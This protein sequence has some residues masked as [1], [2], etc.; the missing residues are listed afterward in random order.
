MDNLAPPPSD[1]HSIGNHELRFTVQT[2]MPDGIPTSFIHVVVPGDDW[3]LGDLEALVHEMHREFEWTAGAY[4]DINRKSG[5]V[6]ASGLDITAVV[7]SVVQTIPTVHWLLDR[8][9]RSGPPK[10]ARDSALRRAEGTILTRYPHEK[11]STLTLNAEEETHSSWVFEFTGATS[12]SYRVEVVG[13][14]GGRTSA[15]Y[16]TWRAA[17]STTKD[18]ETP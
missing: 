9:K 16:V 18:T 12:D 15:E 3:K 13:T 4:V 14:G 10:D 17:P 6:G 1:P 8:L 11:R 7:L 5:G 2:W